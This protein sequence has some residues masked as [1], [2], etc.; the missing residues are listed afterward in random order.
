MGE[1]ADYY[2]A[3][4]MQAEFD[5]DAFNG[6]YYNHIWTDYQKGKLKWA[7]KDGQ[8]ILIKHMLDNHLVNTKKYLEG[9][10]STEAINEWI[11]AF[12]VEI[13]KRKLLPL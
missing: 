5:G 1:M 9:L 11:D 6:Y 8:E 7:T 3:L 13:E 2:A 4:S 12:N 10:P